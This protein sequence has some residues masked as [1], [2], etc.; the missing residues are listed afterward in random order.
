MVFD[1]SPRWFRLAVSAVLIT[2]A[3]GCGGGGDGSSGARGWSGTIDTMEGVPVVENL[4]R[5]IVSDATIGVSERWRSGVEE[6]LADRRSWENAPEVRAGPSGRVF[7]LDPQA[8]RILMFDAGSGKPIGSIGSGDQGRAGRLQDPLG[9]AVLSDAVMV[10]ER[11]AVRVFGHDGSFRREIEIPVEDSLL[12]HGVRLYGLDSLSAVMLQLQGGAP[13][14]RRYKSSG[15]VS[16]YAKPSAVSRYYP[17]ATRRRCWRVG[18]G[19]SGLVLGSCFFPVVI[20]VDSTGR[21][22][23]EALIVSG[24]DSASDAELQ[25]LKEESRAHWRA[26]GEDLSA[27]VIEARVQ[28]DVHLHR[29]KDKY[30]EIRYDRGT[31]L[32]SVLEE[33]PEY[34]GGGDAT[35]QLFNEEGLYVARVDFPEHW[36][37]HDILN[38][39]IYALVRDA[40]GGRSLRA[41]VLDVPR[42]RK[43][44]AE[45]IQKRDSPTVSEDSAGA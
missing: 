4:A 11:H 23:R 34:L 17:D 18:R 38:S 24:A 33:T 7:L 29:I 25:Q 19:P 5:P 31:G 32:V 16:R 14:W 26:V 39:I 10:G 30:R 36:V 44:V 45:G 15:E 9:I 12:D 37:A 22:V 28:R 2:G 6:R 42:V 21:V 13:V 40:D 20:W 43:D 8:P 27:R 3:P 1:G 41:Y 35:L